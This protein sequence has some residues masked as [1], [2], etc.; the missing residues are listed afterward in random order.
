[1]VGVAAL[2]SEVC[3][4]VGSLVA[5]LLVPALDSGEY[6][7][8]CMSNGLMEAVSTLLGPDSE[9]VPG[10]DGG[11][12]LKGKVV[13]DCCRCRGVCWKC[14]RGVAA[15]IR[16]VSD[17]SMLRWLLLLVSLTA[18][19]GEGGE[20][21]LPLLGAVGEKFLVVSGLSSSSGVGGRGEVVTPNSN[22]L[23]SVK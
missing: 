6:L 4:S 22:S 5:V 19:G 9:E 14:G 21:L 17:P 11:G 12:V 18:E 7:G 2:D 8:T 23:A 20:G 3:L 15:S 13:A 1:M 10:V 16:S